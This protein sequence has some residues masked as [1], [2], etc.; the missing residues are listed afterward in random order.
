MTL[1]EFLQDYTGFDFGN[2]EI[3]I[4]NQRTAKSYI[5]KLDKDGNLYNAMHHDFTVE[6]DMRVYSFTHSDRTMLITL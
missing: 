3:V 2:G 5:C 6:S 4:V 1:K